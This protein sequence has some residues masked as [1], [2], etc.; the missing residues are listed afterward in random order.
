MASSHFTSRFAP[1]AGLSKDIAAIFG[2]PDRGEALVAEMQARLEAVTETIGD[3]AE[4]D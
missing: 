4:F 3:D 1:K 2:V